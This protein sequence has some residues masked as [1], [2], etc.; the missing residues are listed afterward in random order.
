MDVDPGPVLPPPPPPNP[1]LTYTANGVTDDTGAFRIVV[2]LDDR[3]DGRTLRSRYAKCLDWGDCRGYRLAVSTLDTNDPT[4]IV[5]V[6]DYRRGEVSAR[7]ITNAGDT[8]PS[9]VQ[10][11]TPNLEQSRLVTETLAWGST[12]PRDNIAL[13]STMN[14]LPVAIHEPFDPLGS[15]D[16]AT[17][18]LES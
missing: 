7:L 16:R 9:Q 6:Y 4:D 10:I 14:D 2:D 3:A 1:Y 18:N 12:P 11:R 15:S 8:P 13:P 17:T 5:N